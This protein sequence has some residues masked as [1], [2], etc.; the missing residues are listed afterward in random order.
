MILKDRYSFIYGRN[1]SLLDDNSS[2]LRGKEA[3]FF[4]KELALYGIQLKNISKLRPTPRI[5]DVLLN[6][7]FICLEEETLYQ[8]IS[9]F[10]ELPVKAIC[11]F[12]E[13]SRPFIE[14]WQPYI[15]AY[16]ILF[17]N[18]D[19][20]NIR[21]YM[22]IQR[23]NSSLNGKESSG[24]LRPAPTTNN[25]K[26]FTGCTLRITKRY[27]YILTPTG[28]FVKVKST[29][30]DSIKTGYVFTGIRAVDFSYFRYSALLI[31][32]SI[33]LVSL[34]SAFI[35]LRPKS[36]VLI[37]ANS[38]IRLQ[39]NYFGRIVKVTPLNKNGSK[40]TNSLKLFNTSLDDSVLLILR[41]GKEEEIIKADTQVSIFISGAESSTLSLKKTENFINDSKMN[42][43]INNN[44]VEHEI[45]KPVQK[46]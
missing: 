25:T 17:G 36:T 32:F 43:T 27:Y 8:P 11:E 24:A 40:V 45:N 41:E 30:G 21:A 37:N 12:T 28:D 42:V 46:K 3:F 31:I 6:I 34:L 14:K 16:V 22:N 19:Y 39:T 18:N 1:L 4:V 2:A 38:Y 44:G 15:L 26:H 20:A 5:K 23:L 35:Y 10:R 7:A 13:K 9:K 29:A 33:I